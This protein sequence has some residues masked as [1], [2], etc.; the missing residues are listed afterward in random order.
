MK[1]ITEHFIK[2]Q[3]ILKNP[4]YL[5]NSTEEICLFLKKRLKIKIKF[6]SM[7]ME[8]HMLMHHIL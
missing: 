4:N 8:V 1:K 5:I 2:I 3:N 6:L 7:V